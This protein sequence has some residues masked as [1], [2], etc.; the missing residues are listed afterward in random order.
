M[1]KGILVEWTLVKK[2]KEKPISA[3]VMCMKVECTT[4]HKVTWKGC[5]MH[6][7]AALIGVKEEDRCLNWKTG[8]H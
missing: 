2:R 4:C 7:D 6:I 3:I 1:F 5:G 8:K